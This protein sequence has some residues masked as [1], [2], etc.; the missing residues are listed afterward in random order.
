VRRGQKAAR[1]AVLRG[2][3][4]GGVAATHDLVEVV[5]DA[6]DRVEHGAIRV[7]LGA[8]V[9]VHEVLRKVGGVEV[10]VCVWWGGVSGS[11][12]ECVQGRNRLTN[13]GAL[14]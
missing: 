13:T 12:E 10:C 3:K 14:A 4:G 6:V 2:A 5:E 11:S 7:V 1:S 9:L 8:S